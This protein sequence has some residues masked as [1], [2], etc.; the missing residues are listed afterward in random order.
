MKKVIL[1]FLLV[2]ISLFFASNSAHASTQEQLIIINKSVNELAFFEGGKLVRTFQ[3]A[4]GRNSTLTPEG[5]FRIVN[6]ITNRPYYSGGIPGGSP[7]NPLGDRWLGLDARGTYGTTYAIHGNNNASS[8]GNYVSA[9]CVRMHNDEVRWLYSR[10]N[11]NTKVV[12]TSS[13][14]SFATIAVSH[15]YLNPEQARYMEAVKA[16]NELQKKLTSFN[17][18]INN[19]NLLTINQLYDGFTKQLKTTEQK[20]G[21][22]SGSRNRDELGNRYIRPAKEAIERT[23]YEVS[24]YR[25]IQ[26]IE[27]LAISSNLSEAENEM[28]KLERLKRRAAEIKLAGNYKDLPSSVNHT[29]SEREARVQGSILTRR[30]AEFESAISSGNMTTINHL[31]DHFTS[32]LRLTEL[33]IGQV[34]GRSTRDKLGN[35]Y[36]TP[37]KV[38]IERTIYEVSQIRLIQSIEQLAKSGSLQNAES[39]MAKLERL[40]RRAVEIKQAGNYKQLPNAVHYTLKEREA[41]AQ[42]AIMSRHLIE[43]NSTIDSGNISTIE[44]QYDPFTKQLKITEQKIGQVSGASTRSSLNSDYVTPAKIAV[45]RTIYEVSMLRLMT[46]IDELIT[47]NQ[48]EQAKLDYAM[49]NRLERRAEEIK[50]AGQY[51]ALPG[52]VNDELLLRKQTITEQLFGSE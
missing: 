5:T 3:V 28:A 50:K 6:K 38:A 30:L 16:G 40:K 47:N 19:G 4:T 44:N 29:L 22:V 20:I 13:K 33:K 18:A 27:Q 11:L 17:R 24:Q 41:H 7:S 1:S 32:Q 36:I 31:Y 9:G 12:I 25:L 46:E 21:Q 48:V 2:F 52:A 51:K 23:I 49:L 26:Q 15:G 10:V 39:E 37:A 45:E 42:G 14:S 34:A 43:F 8:I 35:L